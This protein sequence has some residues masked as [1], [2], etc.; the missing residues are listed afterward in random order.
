MVMLNIG[1]WGQFHLNIIIIGI[2]LSSEGSAFLNIKRSDIGN[3]CWIHLCIF[4]STFEDT[5]RTSLCIYFFF[6]FVLFYF[7]SADLY[8]CWLLYFHCGYV[9]AEKRSVRTESR[10][11][12]WHYNKEQVTSKMLYNCSFGEVIKVIFQSLWEMLALVNILSMT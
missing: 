3:L 4:F 10:Q 2:I 9:K 11:K 12:P 7:Q 1:E 5:Y 8:L 6:V